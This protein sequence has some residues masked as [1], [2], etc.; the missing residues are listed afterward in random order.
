MTK[1]QFLIKWPYLNPTRDTINPYFIDDLDAVIAHEI[2]KAKGQPAPNPI[3]EAYDA[4]KPI[5]AK[6]WRKGDW[7]KKHTETESIDESG[8]TW[9]CSFSFDKHPEKWEIYT[10]AEAEKVT[11]PAKPKF[12]KDRFERVF[13][14]LLVG[15]VYVNA[16]KGTE[17]VLKQLDAYYA[18]KKGGSND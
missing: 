15:D 5:R 1:E 10:E 4:Y 3:R 12:D 2:A 18:T 9:T 14:A 13:C 16:L 11:A 8:K 17:D 7:I 6:D